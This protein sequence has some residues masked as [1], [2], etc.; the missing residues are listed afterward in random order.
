VQAKVSSFLV[1]Q[2]LP[3]GIA[4]RKE[5]MEAAG[6][7]WPVLPAFLFLEFLQRHKASC[8]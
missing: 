2:L 6:T 3:R 7:D 5:L 1:S 8:A 4:Y